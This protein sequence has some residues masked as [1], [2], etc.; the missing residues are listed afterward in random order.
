L[1]FSGAE[2]LKHQTLTCFPTSGFPPLGFWDVRRQE[3]SHLGF[4]G[5]ETLKHQT[6]TCFPTSRI[7]PSGFRELGVL[8]LANMWG[9]HLGTPGAKISKYD[10]FSILYLSGYRKS[11]FWDLRVQ[12]ISPLDILNA[13]TTK[14]HDLAI[15]CYFGV[16][17]IGI[18]GLAS[19]RK[20]TL[21][22]PRGRNTEMS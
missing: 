6:L 12:E 10:N 16:S 15:R 1:G 4:S 13:E 11:G 17:H 21:R 9:P 7:H 8:R 3:V 22:F 2:T 14:Y 20:P 18:L 19:T 5:A